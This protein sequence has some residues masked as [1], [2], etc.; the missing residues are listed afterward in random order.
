MVANF[1]DPTSLLLLHSLL[2][3]AIWVCVR[4]DSQEGSRH[5]P[6]ADGEPFEVDSFA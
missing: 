2:P 4:A 1:R 6:E 5:M 3:V